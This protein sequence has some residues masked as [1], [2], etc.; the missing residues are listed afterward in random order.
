MLF[1]IYH[2]LVLEHERW[3]IN[4]FT[5]VAVQN[6]RH[7]KTLK[8]GENTKTSNGCR[9]ISHFNILMLDSISLMVL[10]SVSRSSYFPITEIS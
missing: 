3:I 2:Q 8:M 7:A 9:R 6:R 10:R 1:S 4:F 5:D